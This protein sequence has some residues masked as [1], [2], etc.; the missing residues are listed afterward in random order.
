MSDRPKTNSRIGS[1]K[2]LLSEEV[3]ENRSRGASVDNDGVGPSARA[4]ARRESGAVR[5][6]G[7]AVVIAASV[8]ASA[9]LV[10]PA[11]DLARDLVI[12]SMH[13]ETASIASIVQL[14]SR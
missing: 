8:G 5:D 12:S 9:R 1:I 2:L 7:L 6:A 3:L 10:D 14:L 11:N 4:V 13:D